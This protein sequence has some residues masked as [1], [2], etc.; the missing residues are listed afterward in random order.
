MG[1]ISSGLFCGGG[2]TFWGV[3]HIN[4]ALGAGWV[5]EMEGGVDAPWEQGPEI[6]PQKPWAHG[7]RGSVHAR[8]CGLRCLQENHPPLRFPQE[9]GTVEGLGAKVLVPPL[10]EE[11][12][13]AGL[14]L[15]DSGTLA[16]PL[17]CGAGVEGSPCLLSPRPPGSSLP[18]MVIPV[19]T[20]PPAASWNPDM[21]GLG[22][23]A[24]SLG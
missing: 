17:A 20:A 23:C 8:L 11:W 21:A 2:A 9:R 24:E 10:P 12:L 19:T 6:V 22:A 4:L 15:T 14:G 7:H 5:W 18:L 16:A 1:G 13:R 3:G